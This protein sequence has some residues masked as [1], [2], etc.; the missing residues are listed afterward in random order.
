M[1]AREI[2]WS[3][4]VALVL[5]STFLVVIVAG[6]PDSLVP[7]AQAQYTANGQY[8]AGGQ[9]APYHGQYG[10]GGQYGSG[11]SGSSAPS[12][13]QEALNALSSP[14][15]GSNGQAENRKLLRQY[16]RCGGTIASLPQDVFNTLRAQ[17]VIG[18]QVVNGVM[19]AC[20]SGDEEHCSAL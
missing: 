10:A 15:L 8:G 3:I 16:I 13:E 6:A 18:V 12:C 4:L 5:M 17:G 14:N 1:C 7:G 2:G 19:R 20:P 11:G 9:Y